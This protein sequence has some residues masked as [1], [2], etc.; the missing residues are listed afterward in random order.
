METQRNTAR[1]RKR[2]PEYRL[3]W[4]GFLSRAHNRMRIHKLVWKQDS[5][6]GEDVG[7]LG[8]MTPGRG[9]PHAYFNCLS[10][11]MKHALQVIGLGEQVD[12]VHLLDAISG[13]EQASQITRNG[14]RIAG[15]V[16]HLVRSQSDEALDHVFPQTAPW[17][18]HHY[19]IRPQLAP[20]TSQEI[21]CGRPDS[22]H[23]GRRIVEQVGMRSL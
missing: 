15:D 7:I 3:S 10:S 13:A 22:L 14:R 4:N 18:V 5:I 16:G 12:Q 21:E 11:K 6:V 1:I 23:V 17:R 2:C 8:L 19:E 9:T 20:R